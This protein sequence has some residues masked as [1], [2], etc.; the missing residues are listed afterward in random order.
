LQAAWLTYAPSI[1]TGND[2]A[3]YW[4]PSWDF[5][6]E[7]SERTLAVHDSAVTIGG[8]DTVAGSKGSFTFSGSIQ[9]QAPG[10]FSMQD[11]GDCSWWFVI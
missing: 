11:D 9:M 6:S 8:P 2:Q 1:A 10:T 3:G 7:A 5:M 4:W